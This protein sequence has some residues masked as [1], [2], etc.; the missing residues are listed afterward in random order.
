MEIDG[1]LNV[2]EGPYLPKELPKEYILV[3][4]L[5]ETLVHYDEIND[6]EGQLAMRPGA[7]AF[8]KLMA[9][10]FTIV[11]FTAGTEEYADWALTFLENVHLISHRLYR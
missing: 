5:D 2:V 4:D 10:H 9:P 7:D 6:N 1:T 3:L 11:I 8:L